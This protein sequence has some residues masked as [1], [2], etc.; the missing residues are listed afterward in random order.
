MTLVSQLRSQIMDDRATV[1]AFAIFC[2]DKMATA[3]IVEVSN[4]YLRTEVI[5]GSSAVRELSINLRDSETNTLQKLLSVIER[6]Y[7]ASYTVE[8]S[9]EMMSNHAAADIEEIG[10]TSIKQRSVMLR[11]HRFSDEELTSILTM[12]VLR[13]NP[14]Y[15]IDTVPPNEHPLVLLLARAEAM[16]V[17]STNAAKRRGLDADVASLLSIADACDRSYRDDLRRIGRALPS[18]SS[19]DPGI[20]TRGDVVVSE[21]SRFGLRTGYQ[22]PTSASHPPLSPVLYTPE[23]A[24]VEDYGVMLRWERLQGPSEKFFSMELWRDTQPDVRRSRNTEAVPTTAKVVWTSREGYSNEKEGIG[25]VTPNIIASYFDGWKLPDARYPIRD[26]DVQSAL[27]PELTYYYRLFV[28][29]QNGEWASSDVVSVT[30]KGAR[31]EFSR[32]VGTPALSVTTGPRAGGT[33]VTLRGRNFTEQTKV[34]IAGKPV[35][36]L[37]RVD[38]T[39]IT[40]ETPEVNPRAPRQADVVIV[41]PNGLRDIY[42]DA[43]TWT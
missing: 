34:F 28:F 9:P 43:W 26:A 20:D 4:G 14:G 38:A 12:A 29:T 31:A 35:A 2:K 39:T 37:V 22:S 33:A 3:A 5:N 23:G 18:P 42:S 19:N 36:N 24:D 32:S 11:V 30:L 1:P 10:G 21:S 6:D 40:F 13:H 27:E 8:R 25:T 41:S 7:A 17:L 15:T 16:R